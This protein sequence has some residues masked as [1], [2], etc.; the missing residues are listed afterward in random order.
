MK[1]TKEQTSI[2]LSKLND[3]R[4]SRRPCVI[5]GNNH[6]TVNDC[7]FETR[8]FFNEGYKLGTPIATMPM[9]TITCDNCGN[10]LFLSAIRMGLVNVANEES[11]NSKD[12]GEEK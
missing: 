10:T 5:C 8:E 6:W 3:Y 11:L 2:I 1:L 7:I 9:I 12:N 4:D